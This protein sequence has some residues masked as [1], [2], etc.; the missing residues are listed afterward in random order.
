MGVQHGKWDTMRCWQVRLLV[1]V[2]RWASG[3]VRRMERP[4]AYFTALDRH[5]ESCEAATMQR[6]HARFLADDES[7]DFEVFHNQWD[8]T[9]AALQALRW[10]VG[11]LLRTLKECVHRQNLVYVSMMRAVL[12]AGG[13]HDMA[14]LMPRAQLLAYLRT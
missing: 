11:G 5:L 13:A 9:V 12:A 3:H 7:Y 10:A 1:L 4:G 6:R 8:W 14:R 2:H